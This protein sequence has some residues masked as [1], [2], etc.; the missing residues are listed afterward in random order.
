[1]VDPS[2]IVRYDQTD[3][4]LEELLIFCIC[5]AGKKASTIAPRVHKLI[6]GH[7]LGVGCFLKYQLKTLGIGCHTVKARTIQD[8]FR[9]GLDLR[10]CSVSDLEAIYGIGPKTARAFIMWSRPNV[11]HACLDTHILKWLRD[12]GVEGVP[13]ST[14]TGKKYLTLE[15]TY[16]KMVPEGK[17]A[18][19]FDLEIW[20]EYSGADK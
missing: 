7:K 1:M 12:Q 11:Q 18:A 14:P 20:K 15:Q 19:E 2:N 8:A 10:E 13:K 6:H 4:E 16:L 5:V 9:A 3:A 17:T